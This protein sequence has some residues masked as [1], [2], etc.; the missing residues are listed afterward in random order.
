MAGWNLA[1]V[2]EVVANEIPQASALIY[3][4]RILI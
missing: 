2:L 1:D 4:F 3:G